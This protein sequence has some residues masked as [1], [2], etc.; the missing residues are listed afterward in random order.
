MIQILILATFILTSI[1]FHRILTC[2]N[3]REKKLGEVIGD[4][5]MRGG[6]MRVSAANC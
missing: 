4:P 5:D 6:C 1:T 2:Y 3:L